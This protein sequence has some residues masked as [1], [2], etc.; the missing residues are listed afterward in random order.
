MQRRHAQGRQAL[1]GV[2]GINQ[3]L[4]RVHGDMAAA[5]V[6][7]HVHR[8]GAIQPQQGAVRQD[9]FAAFARS[10]AVVSQITGRHPLDR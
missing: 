6:H 3:D 2:F 9:Q 7:G 4:A 10:H 8:A 1:R 5:R